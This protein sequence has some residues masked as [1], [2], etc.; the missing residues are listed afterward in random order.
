MTSRNF[1]HGWLEVRLK[2]LKHQT[3]E[4]LFRKSSSN[5]FQ[6]ETTWKKLGKSLIGAMP[7]EFLS[8]RLDERNSR[9]VFHFFRLALD[10]TTWDLEERWRRSRR[11]STSCSKDFLRKF[12]HFGIQLK[13]CFCCRLFL[14]RTETT[15]WKR[16][17]EMN[18]QSGKLATDETAKI[19][20]SR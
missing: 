2:K 4:M 7:N 6:G 17:E 8:F 20:T 14:C 15:Q 12:R 13:I 3:R 18:V 19:A 10:E 9:Q 11:R 5:P 16:W 1:I